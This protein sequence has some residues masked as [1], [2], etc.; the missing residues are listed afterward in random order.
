[1]SWFENIHYRLIP[2][3]GMAMLLPM[4]VAWIIAIQGL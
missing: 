2:S 1:M 4:L 3:L